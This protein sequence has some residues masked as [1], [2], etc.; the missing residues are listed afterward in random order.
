MAPDLPCNVY[1]IIMCIIPYSYSW[2]L[3]NCETW[4]YQ[5]Q[6]YLRTLFISQNVRLIFLQRIIKEKKNM[7]MCL[8]FTCLPSGFN[9]TSIFLLHIITLHLQMIY[10]MK[11]VDMLPIRHYFNLSFMLTLLCFAFFF[12]GGFR[13]SLCRVN[14]FAVFILLLAYRAVVCLNE[15][16]K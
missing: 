16:L 6:Q 13:F 12:F 9:L 5:R 3:G 4:A 8:T 2:R 14:N 7:C 1:K 11:C 10:F 15:I